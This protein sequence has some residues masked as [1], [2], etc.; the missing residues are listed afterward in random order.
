MNKTIKNLLLVFTLICAIV[1]VVFII[2]LIILNRDTGGDGDTA[3]ATSGSI[4]ANSIESSANPPQSP[5]DN[6]SSGVN[7][8]SESPPPD[9]ETGKRYELLYSPAQK[10][11]LYA[12]EEL[13]E[14]EEMDSGDIF[15]FTD[16]IRASLEICP[17]Y[18]PDGAEA[19]AESYLDGYLEGNES[20]VSGTSQIK[21]SA[22][23]GVFVSGVNAGET[24]EAW[25]HDIIG[26]SGD[27]GMA[28]V[29]RYSDNDQ[30]N[31]LYAILDTLEL[32]PSP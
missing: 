5:A 17:A 30:R 10:L 29:I 3:A 25:I 11:V 1:F 31:A 27:M 9:Q 32:V 6:R 12:D 26:V 24:F 21:R 4:P 7:R 14:H 18:A 22:L 13:F 8:A 20:F 19:C 15:F 16:D 23:S 28:F 2:E